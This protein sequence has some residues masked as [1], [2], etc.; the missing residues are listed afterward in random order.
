MNQGPIGYKNLLI[1]LG[2]EK[3]EEENGAIYVN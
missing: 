3:E 1:K 2:W